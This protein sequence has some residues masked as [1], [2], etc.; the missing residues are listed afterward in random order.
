MSASVLPILASAEE[1]H[2]Q[3]PMPAWVFGAIAFALFLVALGV[4]WSFRN[5][6][7]KVGSPGAQQDSPAPSGH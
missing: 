1:V 4:L 7:A 3:L 6:A 2:R 5:T